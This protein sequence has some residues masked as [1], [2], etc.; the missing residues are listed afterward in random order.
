MTDQIADLINLTQPPIDMP[1]VYSTAIL[2]NSIRK[3]LFNYQEAHVV[4]LINILLKKCVALDGSDTG[5]G[6]TYMALAVAKELNRR[7]III[8]PRSLMYV[9]TE[10]CKFMGVEAYDIVN[11]ETI[12]NAKSYTD[13]KFKNRRASKYIKL[14]EYDADTSR[15]YC[16]YEWTL[17]ADA[18]IIF[19]EA[20]RCKTL[21]TDN[22][23]LL[24]S[25]KQAI[26]NKNPVLILSATIYEKFSDMRIPFY[27]FGIIPSAINYEHFIKVIKN[28]YRKLHKD[29]NKNQFH[30]M[31]IYEE[32]KE[33]SSRIRVKDLGSMFP[34][35]QWCAQQF[36]AEDTDKIVKL[37]DDIAKHMMELKNNPGKN[38]LAQIQKLKQEIELRKIPIFVE[39][40]ESYMEQNKSIII[41]V[42]YL[43]T[44]KILSKQLNIIAKIHGNQTAEE[45]D[46]A[47]KMFQSDKTNIIICQ[48]RA[49]GVGISLHDLNGDHPRVVLLNFPDTASDLLQALGRAA[50][51]GAKTPVIQIIITIANVD[52]ERRI[53]EN[54]NRKLTNISIINDGDLTGYDYEI[55]Q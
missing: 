52:Y 26:R 35:N 46:D 34:P 17:P 9:W 28:K 51:A 44:M 8:C 4:K 54:I 29:L 1:K 13:N 53:M 55:K 37:Y 24:I 32:I 6:K 20:H 23:G 42:N 7:P 19:D 5:V 14:V 18:M 30:A 36:I 31:I 48:I 47:I 38:H 27:L 43:E 25:T 3:K 40:A 41:F 22:G 33:F 45:R 15:N 50:R 39:R 11:I 2:S 49:G 10:V 12:K 21:S 16:G